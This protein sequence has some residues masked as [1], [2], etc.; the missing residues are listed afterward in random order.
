[1]LFPFNFLRIKTEAKYVQHPAINIDPTMTA[2]IT[3]WLRLL[4]SAGGGGGGTEEVV[5]G[6]VEVVGNRL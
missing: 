3:S 4:S 5:V 6:H 2:I 1:M